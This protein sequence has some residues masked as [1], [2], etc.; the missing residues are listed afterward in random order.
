MPERWHLGPMGRRLL[1][2][3]LVVSLTTL[4]VHTVGTVLPHLLASTGHGEAVDANWL[5]AA[6]VVA[7]GFAVVISLVVSVRMT[8]PMR[9]ITG[10]A[11][12]F[13]TGDYSVRAPETGRPE[14]AELVEALD[15]AAAEV[16]RSEAAKWLQPE[17]YV[18]VSATGGPPAGFYTSRIK[19]KILTVVPPTTCTLTAEPVPPKLAI[20]RAT[21][22]P[23][24]K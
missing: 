10:M 7:L 1:A 18:L 9:V 21:V 6:T 16:E 15:D 12:A 17:A 13:A 2:G 24:E 3:F 20:P 22:T 8:M 19:P 14:F 5:V 23:V 4:A 11:R